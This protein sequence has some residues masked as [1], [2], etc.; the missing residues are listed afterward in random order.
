LNNVVKHANAT[1]VI[2]TLSQI[3]NHTILVI[4]D[5][6]K[7]FNTIE[8]RNGIGL[9]NIISRTK[10]FNGSVDIQS[11]PG[12]GCKLRVSLPMIEQLEEAKA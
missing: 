8:K 9:N 10:V 2:I 3:N 1:K 11:A 7:G 5:N 12:R 6:G 4:K